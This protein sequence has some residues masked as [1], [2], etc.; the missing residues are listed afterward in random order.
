MWDCGLGEEAGL[1]PDNECT[2]KAISGSVARL[3]AL[4]S[5]T[6]CNVPEASHTQLTYHLR[7]CILPGSAH[8]SGVFRQ[9]FGG[10][11]LCHPLTVGFPSF[12]Q[13]SITF[14][15]AAKLCSP[16]LQS[17]VSRCAEVVPMFCWGCSLRSVF[18][19]LF[20]YLF[21]LH[22]CRCLDSTPERASTRTLTV[23]SRYAGNFSM[24]ISVTFYLIAL[25][26]TSTDHINRKTIIVLETG[27]ETTRGFQIDTWSLY[28]AWW[29]KK[30]VKIVGF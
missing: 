27:M 15:I 8:G 16:L 20:S 24:V 22:R 4:M 12:S 30:C 21:G 13:K 28:D 19:S 23:P 10:V 14:S 3:W 29:F 5:L 1:H 9:N 18:L 17:S 6:L 11:G 25:C 7:P 26:P 2:W